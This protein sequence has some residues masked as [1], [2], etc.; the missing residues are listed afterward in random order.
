MLRICCRH[1][2]KCYNVRAVNAIAHVMLTTCASWAAG[3]MPPM[4]AT[5]YDTESGL[6][7]KDKSSRA[8]DYY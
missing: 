8:E 7:K 4:A 5:A 3:I 2:A 6:T 1:V